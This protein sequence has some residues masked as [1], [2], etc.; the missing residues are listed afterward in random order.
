MLKFFTFLLL[1]V[2]IT[3]NHVKANGDCKG[4]LEGESQESYNINSGDIEIDTDDSDDTEIF[5]SPP[6]RLYESYV[7]SGSDDDGQ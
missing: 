2:M 7:A 5:L 1:I 4:Y 3:N 6:S